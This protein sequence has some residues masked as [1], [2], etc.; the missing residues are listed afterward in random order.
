MHAFKGVSLE[1]P[2]GQ[3]VG[4]IGQNGSGKTTLARTWWVY[5]NQPIMKNAKI[6]IIGAGYYIKGKIKIDKT[7]KTINY[8]FQNPDDQLV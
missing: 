2:E 7:I 1:I 4:I 5:R 8:V 3:I 6:R